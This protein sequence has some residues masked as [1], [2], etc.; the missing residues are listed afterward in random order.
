MLTNKRYPHGL[1]LDAMFE[2]FSAD[3][4]LYC[5]LRNWQDLPADCGNDLDVFVSKEDVARAVR[6]IVSLGAKHNL[7]LRRKTI[8][9]GYLSLLLHNWDTLEEIKIDFF[10]IIHFQGLETIPSGE[11]LSDTRVFNG[12]VVANESVANFIN[13][14]KDFLSENY[15]K[16]K[17]RKE[18]I[19][20]IRSDSEGLKL[21]LYIDNVFGRHG[22]SILSNALAGECE[23]QSA[24]A[25][26]LR[27]LLRQE[28]YKSVP[29]V[30]LTSQA[31]ACWYRLT[32]GCSGFK[33]KN[34]TIALLGPDGSGKSTISE[35]LV[36]D[37]FPKNQDVIYR[38]GRPG[39]I[40]SLLDVFNKVMSLFRLK[41]L[42][43]NPS[44]EDAVQDKV[45]SS[46]MAA[47]Y[48]TYYFFDFWLG[49][50]Y[51]RTIKRRYVKILDRYWYDYFF[52]PSF[53]NL[54]RWMGFFQKILPR[55]T[56]LL[57][58][59]ASADAI[60][61]RKKELARCQIVEQ[62]ERALSLGGKRK[63]ARYIDTDG[64]VND[65]KRALAEVVGLIL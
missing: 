60:Y 45:H 39:F 4:I 32:N 48:V 14:Y 27:R 9:Y 5:I 21:R 42:P 59:R 22:L 8:K 2:S 19:D 54:P 3:G 53:S 34:I 11:V 61:E 30:S 44:G 51:F 15:I 58:L 38:H 46:Q 63:E 1:F 7:V 56:L 16:E 41:K 12:I 55:A 23:S 18:I 24:S 13:L 10:H 52:L 29:L 35:I 6:L 31:Y 47:L 64:G 25:A 20:M 57:I 43:P 26:K 33:S 36:K 65:T 50:L 49:E 37:I 17:Y 40:P 62:N 28:K